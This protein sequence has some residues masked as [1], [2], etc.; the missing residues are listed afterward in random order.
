M[1]QNLSLSET[2]DRIMAIRRERAELDREERELALRE[3]GLALR[4]YAPASRPTAGGRVQPSTGSAALD[5]FNRKRDAFMRDGL[6]LGEATDAVLRANVGLYE[7]V[8]RERLRVRPAVQLAEP[9]SP[10]PARGSAL[11]E[12]V[13]KR[14]DL[15]EKRGVSL[16]EATMRVATDDPRLYEAVDRERPRAL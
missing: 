6:S 12:F 16:S 11:A 13:R 14:D 1:Q 9:T 5:E 4:E 3:A 7:R 8:D 15:I 2:T 10:A